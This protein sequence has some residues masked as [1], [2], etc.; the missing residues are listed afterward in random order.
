M[1]LAYRTACATGAG[2]Y[3]RAMPTQIAAPVRV[4]F[5]ASQDPRVAANGV[6]SHSRNLKA[7][8]A[9]AGAV[10]VS[11]LDPVAAPGGRPRL[12]A[13]RVRG[14][15][16]AGPDRRALGDLRARYAILAAAARADGRLR[17]ADVV[18]AQDFVAAA[19]CLD[20]LKGDCPP[21]VLAHHANGLPAGELA[22]RLRLGPEAE[23]VR[24]CA[25]QSARAFAGAARV[26][27]VSPWAAEVL[28]REAGVERARIAVVPNGV[29]V[30][31]VPPDGRSRVAGRVLAVGQL[32]DRKGFDLLVRAMAALGARPPAEGIGAHAIVLG[33]GPARAEL[34]AQARRLE[35]PVI[36]AGAASPAGVGAQMRTAA[37]FALPSRA[38]NLPMALL[39]AMAAGLPCVGSDVGAVA[40]ALRPDGAE[41]CGIVVPPGDAGALASALA[42]LL[43]DPEAAGALGRRAYAR[44]RTV[45]G[46]E[47]MARHWT[48]V[49]R[50]VVADAA[51]RRP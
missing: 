38:E 49:Y 22:A 17:R 33:D 47:A 4:A 25:A 9:A 1:F 20:A 42:G 39:E 37:V 40:Q 46:T 48:E 12:F 41:P 43:A 21:V 10:L 34:E 24:F 15:L 5:V 23:S 32:V 36:F 28:A 29:A 6:N 11:E 26:V 3:T 8:L 19:A 13:A 2:R 18:H 44:A 50:A 51:A 27:A 30:P 35:A 45:Y 14:R 7:A 31:S 16:G